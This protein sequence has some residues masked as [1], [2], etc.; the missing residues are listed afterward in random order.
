MCSMLLIPD[1]VREI[2]ERGRQQGLKEAREER[3]KECY[4]RGFE[5][6]LREGL[7]EARKEG[8]EEARKEMKGRLDE[9]F[10]RFGVIIDGVVCLPRT[11][12]V[13][14]FLGLK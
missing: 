2:R 10:Q 9:A 3:R 13:E 14:K 1:A 8:L 4:E 6:G 7:E 11:P 5:E 12:E